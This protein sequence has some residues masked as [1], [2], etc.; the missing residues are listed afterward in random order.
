MYRSRREKGKDHEKGKGVRCL[1][2]AVNQISLWTMPAFSI[3]VLFQNEPHPIEVDPEESVAVLRF[4]LFSISGLEPSE[5]LVS[6]L[7]PAG[8]LGDELDELP[9][10]ALNIAPG[11]WAILEKKPA[12]SV[13]APAPAQSPLM[14]T[15]NNMEQ[16]QRIMHDRLAAGLATAR[17]HDD[18]ALQALARAVV[19]WDELRSKAALHQPKALREQLRI[20]RP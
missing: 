10:S 1:R 2:R 14:R 15:G 6:G 3:T 17:T 7:G 4:Q 9:A 11:T 19:P 13:P 8:G 12:A 20:E 16:Q 5:Q 18:P